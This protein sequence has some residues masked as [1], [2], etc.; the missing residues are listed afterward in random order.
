MVTPTDCTVVAYQFTSQWNIITAPTCPSVATI[1]APPFNTFTLP[2]QTCDWCSAFSPV[3]Q[4]GP[5]CLRTD[6]LYLLES[7]TFFK[8]SQEATSPSSFSDF[9]ECLNYCGY[10]Y[11]QGCVSVEIVMTY[12]YDNVGTMVWYCNL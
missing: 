12:M 9:C 10:L 5:G 6:T 7:F 4:Y 1:D 2:A 3:D 8:G 11:P